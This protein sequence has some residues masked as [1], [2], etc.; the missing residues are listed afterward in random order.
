MNVV[1]ELLIS[2]GLA[3]VS[4]G[5]LT[6]AVPAQ[7]QI[8]ERSIFPGQCSPRGAA[9][10]IN[11]GG[12][13]KCQP[14]P[15]INAIATGNTGRTRTSRGGGGGGDPGSGGGG[16]GSGGGGDDGN[17]GGDSGFGGGGDPGT[18]G[19]DSGHGGGGDPG[20]RGGDSGFGGAG[21]P[22]N[23]STGEPAPRATGWSAE[24][25]SLTYH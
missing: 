1:R 21:D 5:F 8:T 25:A 22:G 24:G 9:N 19:G 17:G 12:G 11:D 6:I 13:E 23:G 10:I 4:A 16:S 18:R 15:A 14:I 3:V 7:G 20:T 2:T